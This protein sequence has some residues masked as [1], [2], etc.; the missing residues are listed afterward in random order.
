MKPV[1]KKIIITLSIILCISCSSILDGGEANKVTD[2]EHERRRKLS[3]KYCVGDQLSMFVDLESDD[4]FPPAVIASDEIKEIC[5][6]LEIS[7]C[8]LKQLQTATSEFQNGYHEFTTVKVFGNGILDWIGKIGVENFIEATRR[9]N[10][11]RPDIDEFMESAK[12][13]I[14]LL[15]KNLKSMSYD[16]TNVQ[17]TVRKYYAGFI[18][19]FCSPNLHESF[20]ESRN[21]LDS[22][23]KIVYKFKNL[24]EYKEMIKS[25]Y[26]F[27]G[28]HRIALSVIQTLK[29]EPMESLPFEIMSEYKTQYILGTI[30][31][32]FSNY[33]TADKFNESDICQRLPQT[34]GLFHDF[35]MFSDVKRIYEYIHAALKENFRFNPTVILPEK[36]ADTIEF[37][38][39]R[40]TNLV[41]KHA[42]VELKDDQGFDM[43]NNR[44]NPI[45]WASQKLVRVVVVFLVALFAI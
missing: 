40:Q 34:T 28:R 22:Q 45:F 37:Y 35:D 21:S 16:W 25:V 1:S 4:R 18:C 13:E 14:K 23:A 29:D 15:F 42:K 20:H 32:C 26:A 12:S 8:S 44:L 6:A 7:C 17:K 43:V 36:L 19:E 10:E 41:L 27:I 24:L 11:H 33:K 5:P 30:D 39:P 2:S 31:S 9:A 38:Q 3:N